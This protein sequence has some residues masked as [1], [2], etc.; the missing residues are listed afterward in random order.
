MITLS[1]L[2][3]FLLFIPSGAG[4]VEILMVAFATTLGIPVASA[5]AATLLIRG[6][7]YIFGLTAGYLSM[8]YFEEK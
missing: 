8:L 6:I 2:I 1:D 7:Y 3:G 5:I 4:I